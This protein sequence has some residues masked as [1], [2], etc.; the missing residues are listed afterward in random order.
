MRGRLI[1][2]LEPGRYR[3]VVEDDARDLLESLGPQLSDILMSGDQELT[4]RL[5][6][7]A[8]ADD[9]EREAEFRRLMG[10]DLLA[11]RFD[12]L[13]QLQAAV[14]SESMTTGELESFLRAVNSVRLV[15]SSV[16]GIES[17][18]DAHEPYDAEDDDA[19]P[20]IVYE[21]LSALLADGIWALELD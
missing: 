10:D 21:W 6:P 15:L 1:A 18:E 17:E 3:L 7:P 11:R 8:Y 13:D 14:E 12:D 20:R 5:F 4:T 9:D 16:I 19:V 2:R